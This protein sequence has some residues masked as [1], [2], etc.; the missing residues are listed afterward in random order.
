MAQGG[1]QAGASQGQPAGW[2]CLAQAQS[3]KFLP[4]R[5]EFLSKENPRWQPLT[6]DPFCCPSPG[7]AS[8]QGGGRLCSLG[9]LQLSWLEASLPA[10]CRLLPSGGG[11][12]TFTEKQLELGQNQK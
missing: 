2:Q 4:R 8:W 12:V 7:A 6:P 10:A 1:F 5:N 11:Q 9:H 3:C